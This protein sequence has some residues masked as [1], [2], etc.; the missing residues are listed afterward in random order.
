MSGEEYHVLRNTCTFNNTT[1]KRRRIDRY[2][3]ARQN[4]T[5]G[6]KKMAVTT[7]NSKAENRNDDGLNKKEIHSIKDIIDQNIDIGK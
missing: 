4:Y 1:T 6:C 3:A 5:N 7:R 2:I